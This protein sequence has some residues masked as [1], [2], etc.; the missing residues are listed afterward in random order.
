MRPKHFYFISSIGVVLESTVT[1]VPETLPS[2]TKDDHIAASPHGYSESKF[3]AEYVI[4][5]AAKILEIPCSM[6]RVGQISGDTV[7]GVWK[8]CQAKSSTVNCA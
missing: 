7:S 1:P 3:V 4:T 2:W 5:A 8:V 6:A